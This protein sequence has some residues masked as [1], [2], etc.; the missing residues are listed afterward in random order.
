[1]G[2]AL[3]VNEIAKLIDHCLHDEGAAGVRDAALLGYCLAAGLD[4][5]FFLDI[6]KVN[7][8][9]RS[10]KVIFKGNK[11]REPKCRLEPSI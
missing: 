4:A 5:E 2:R 3:H 9:D 1:M 11:E 10:I 8:S 7:A 6:N